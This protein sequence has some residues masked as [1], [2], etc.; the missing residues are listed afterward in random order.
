MKLKKTVALLVGAC[1]SPIAGAAEALPETVVPHT[2]RSCMQ[3]ELSDDACHR[4]I[5]EAG[6]R[7]AS[8]ATSHA[9]PKVTTPVDFDGGN[10]YSRRDRWYDEYK[11][12]CLIGMATPKPRSQVISHYPSFPPILP[13]H[14]KYR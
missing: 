14:L 1:F 2:Y 12:R 9:K 10:L 3:A 4:Q 13:D 6:G 8:A 11:T 5:V 7:V